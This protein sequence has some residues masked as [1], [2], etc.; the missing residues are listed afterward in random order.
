MAWERERKRKR[1]TDREPERFCSL[2]IKSL[3]NIKGSLGYYD[4]LEHEAVVGL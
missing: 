3:V 2:T 1:E 4:D